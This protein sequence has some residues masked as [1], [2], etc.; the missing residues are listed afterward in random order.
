[1]RVG[2]VGA[3][4]TGVSVAVFSSVEVLIFE[5]EA[6]GGLITN[7]WRVE[8]VPIMLVSSREKIAER[9]KRSLEEFSIEVF[10]KRS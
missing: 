7:A 2:I 10:S 8:N 3:G 5:K 1:M 6:V 9:L 4:P